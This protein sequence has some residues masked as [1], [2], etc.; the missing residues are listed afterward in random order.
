M[1]GKKILDLLSNHKN[2]CNEIYDI[3]DGINF[4]LYQQSICR[5]QAKAIAKF[6]KLL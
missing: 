3:T 4:K 6:F 1:Y 2:Q 5:R